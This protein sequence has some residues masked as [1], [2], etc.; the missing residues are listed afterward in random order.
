M[1]D[2]AKNNRNVFIR[3]NDSRGDEVISV[4]SDFGGLNNYCFD[5]SG[6]GSTLQ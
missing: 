5:G 6:M 4:L 2:N 1:E 3:G